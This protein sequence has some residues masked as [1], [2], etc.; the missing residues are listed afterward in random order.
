MNAGA[1]ATTSLIIA[2]MPTTSGNGTNF[3]GKAA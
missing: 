3:Y 1:I 2:K